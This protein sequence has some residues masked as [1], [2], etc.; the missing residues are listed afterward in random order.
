M[1][2]ILVRFK[3]CHWQTIFVY[4]QSSSDLSS[5]RRPKILSA[6]RQ[7]TYSNK[8]NNLHSALVLFP[9]LL[10]GIVVSKLSSHFN[11]P[12]LQPEL[13]Y[14]LGLTHYPIEPRE[15]RWWGE[16]ECGPAGNHCNSVTFF[17]FI[18]SRELVLTHGQ[19]SVCISFPNSIYLWRVKRS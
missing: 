8:L 13:L 12:H 7:L 4:C 16:T 3:P 14:G 17:A 15:R 10:A 2:R 11:C 6:I 9:L 19:T 18:L 5:K 1:S